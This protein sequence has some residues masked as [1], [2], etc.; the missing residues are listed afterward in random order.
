[1]VQEVECIVVGA[2]VIGIAT[3]RALAQS[4]R[5]VI[6]LEAADA[7]GTGTSARNS[8]VV[9]AGLY[10]PKSSLKAQF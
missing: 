6:V 1:M 10:Y 7:V 8:E 3:A 5:G 2:G 4:K 9:H